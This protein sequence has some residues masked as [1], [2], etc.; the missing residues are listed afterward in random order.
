MK[1]AMG[2]QKWLDLGRHVSTKDCVQKLRSTGWTIVATDLSPGAVPFADIDFAK[3]GRYAIVLGNEERGITQEMR[4]LCDHRVYL[5]MRGF[6]QSFSLSVGCAAIASHLSASGALP[7]GS[8][9]VSERERILFMWYLDSVRG[10][11]QILKRNG[12]EFTAA[13]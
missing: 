6:A 3:L 10:A 4:E 13:K 2:S 12:F 1:T 11:R 5:P 8:L 7:A 9:S